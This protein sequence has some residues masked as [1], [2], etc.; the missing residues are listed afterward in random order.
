MYYAV[1]MA[2]G[3]GTR[4]WP[5]SRRN[6]PKQSLKLVG[7]RTMFQHAVERLSP[8]FSIESI[9]TVT[10]PDYVPLLASQVAA[11]TTDNFI[12]EPEGRGTAPA[13]GL[14]AVQLRRR[15]PDATMAVLTADHFISDTGGFRVVLETA[16][17]VAQD[18]RLVT[19]GIK[20]AFPSTGY[21]YI[22]QG[23]RLDV[24][25][26]IPVYAVKRFVE[27]PDS[28]N[29]ERM[30]ASGDYSWNSGMFIWRVDA[31]LSEVKRQMPAF[32]AQLAE[33][34]AAL[35]TSGYS[36]TLERVW[37]DVAEQTIDYGIMENAPNVA[38]I[39]VE[40]GWTD[41]GN[42]SSLFDILPIDAN[43]NILRGPSIAIDTR[44]TLVVG[45]KRLIATIGVEGLVIV[46][47]DDALLVCSK[48]RE[49]EVR[50]IVKQLK[51]EGRSGLF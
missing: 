22:Q 7:D 25:G 34:E 10:K 50:A 8:L 33:V 6:R 23:E 36:S 24:Q 38:V 12:V 48:D 3:S 43:G 32:Y 13:I 35:G 37:P 16:R 2:G 4:L 1:I 17:K 49:Q 46:D 40:I 20:P 14:A 28:G 51:Q 15:D 39:P 26:D 29:A 21:G 11:L 27:K 30:A 42:W 18:G 45:E 5:L 44:N 19:L 41:L 9:F 31:F 47:T